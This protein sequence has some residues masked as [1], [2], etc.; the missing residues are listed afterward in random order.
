MIF[1]SI[2]KEHLP[3]FLT[4]IHLPESWFENTKPAFT[5]FCSLCRELAIA[6][7]ICAVSLAY[8]ASSFCLR[9]LAVLKIFS[10]SSAYSLAYSRTGFGAICGTGARIFRWVPPRRYFGGAFAF[11]R[12][13]RSPPI[14]LNNSTE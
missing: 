3:D 13:T 1:R 12:N 6:T 2:F 7:L 14:F 4:N 5:P 9:I 11:S 10:S 8:F